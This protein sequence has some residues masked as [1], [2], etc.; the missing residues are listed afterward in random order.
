[1]RKGEVLQ[2]IKEESY[3]LKKMKDVYW[4]YHIL[5]KVCLPSTLRKGGYKGREDEAEDV[6]S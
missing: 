6:S 2:I 5:S 3:I 1:V 4:I